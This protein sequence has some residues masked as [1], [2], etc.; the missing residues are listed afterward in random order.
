[1]P[2]TYGRLIYMLVAVWLVAAVLFGAW[3]YVM[4]DV[5]HEGRAD[6]PV[7]TPSQA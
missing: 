4:V 1:M 5:S 2:M 6:V 3:V 7:S